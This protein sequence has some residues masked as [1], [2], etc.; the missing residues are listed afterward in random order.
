MVWIND[1]QAT[2]SFSIARLLEGLLT[3]EELVISTPAG[4]FYMIIGGVSQAIQP[5][6]HPGE[7]VDVSMTMKNNQAMGSKSDDNFKIKIT[8]AGSPQESAPMFLAL[9]QTETFY[10]PPFIMPDADVPISI[11]TYHEEP[12]I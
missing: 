2:Y 8:V 12:A 10:L 1:P 5:I 11:E 7:V 4:D 6:A 3:I 9:N